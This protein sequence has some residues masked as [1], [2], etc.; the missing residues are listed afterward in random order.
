M[1]LEDVV[2]NFIEACEYEKGLSENTRK[3]YQY[4]LKNYL[5]YMK[6][7]EHISSY[8][9]ITK[10]QIIAYLKACF[11]KKEKDYTV[12]HKLTVIKN[13]HKYLLQEKFVTKDV[14]AT[15]VRP[16]T[17]KHLPRSLSQEEV[18]R[19]LDL[20]LNTPFDYRNKAMIELIYATGLRI[21][22]ALQI[23]VYDLDFVNCLVRVKGKGRKERIVP[24]GEYAIDAIQAYLEVRRELLKG[25]TTEVLFL[26]QQGN[27]LS[28]QGFFKM[29]KKLL[30]EKGLPTDISPHSLRH[31]FAT[32]LLSH[33]ADLRSIQML[34][35]HEDIVTT[36]IYTHVSDEKVKEDYEKYH[37]RNH[38]N[39]Q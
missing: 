30:K 3:T 39:E 31:S 28:R 25:K 19:L 24:L 37:P 11:Q 2:S 20:P 18:E 23:T 5:K 29:L 27:P 16:K 36:R 34:L 12:A 14:A 15:I 4:S 38:K 33:G 1:K 26:N 8:Q 13:F 17:K 32:H 9:E 22:E 10:E 21:S 6:E 7:K 35:G